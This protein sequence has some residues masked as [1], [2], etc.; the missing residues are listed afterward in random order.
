[1]WNALVAA[2]GSLSLLAGCGSA[3]HEA[4]Q[5]VGSCSALPM[6]GTWENITPAQLHG[7]RW[8]NPQGNSTCPAAGQTS[9]SGYLA[10]YGANAFVLDPSNAGTIYLGTTNLGIWKSTDCGSTWVHINTGQNGAMLDAGRNWSMVID[11][12]DSNVIYTVAGYG[13][14]GLYKTTNGGVDWTQVLPQNILSITGQG[15][16][17]KITMDPTD[18]RHLLASFHTDCTGTPLP[19]ATTDSMGWGCLAESMDAGG[20]WSLT[21]S[22]L[23]WAGTDGPG[24][25]MVDAKTWF[26]STNSN[27]VWRTTT[28]G[29]PAGGQPAWTKV[30]SGSSNGGIYRAKN[31]I[32]YSG[33]SQ[34]A[35]SK[36]GVTWA[37]IANSPNT[38][39]INGSVTMV[40]DG[41]TFYVGGTWST[42][43]SAP[44]STNPMEPAGPFTTLSSTSTNPSKPLNSL[45]GSPLCGWV[46][47]DSPHHLLYSSNLTDGFWRYVIDVE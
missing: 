22:A 35:W 6:P 12:T 21:T 9:S 45:I 24:Q 17:E 8:C 20:N 31:G 33:G 4:V 37:T 41:K 16:V 42:Y 18:N 5:H 32:F 43:S 47:L 34:V 26:Y 36:D 30:Y 27:D 44:D 23:P 38:N 28:G 15:F 46:D 3:Q 14:E 13:P 25:T 19:G 29:V 10:T 11:P 1:V 39:S 2:W 40:D 7:D